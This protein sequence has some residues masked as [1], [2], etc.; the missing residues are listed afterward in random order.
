MPSQAACRIQ[1]VHAR[2]PSELERSFYG[3]VVEQLA[4]ERRRR[5]WTQPELDAR[6]NVTEGQ[7]AKWE[8][9]QR[10][11]GPF[12]FV[13]W[14]LELGVSLSVERAKHHHHTDEQP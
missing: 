1:R 12:L 13:C 9:F 3:Q 11:P 4:Q 14:A 2:E 5:G 8:S 10:L 7:V 6:L